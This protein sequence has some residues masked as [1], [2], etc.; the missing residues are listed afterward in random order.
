MTNFQEL[1]DASLYS[2]ALE[3]DVAEVVAELT[4]HTPDV[5]HNVVQV[6]FI[7][8]AV[9]HDA[10]RQ[11]FIEFLADKLRKGRGSYQDYTI[12]ELAQGLSYIHLGGWL[13]DQRDALVLMAIGVH[14]KAWTIMTPE[15]LGIANDS[16]EGKAMMGGGFVYTSGLSQEIRDLITA[17]QAWVDEQNA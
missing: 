7:K 1:A 12:D 16:D 3:Q 17:E 5:E 2:D 13:G 15:T 4:G 8:V 9:R 11:V 10:N 14:H 6:G